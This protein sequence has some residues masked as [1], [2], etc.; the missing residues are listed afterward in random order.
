MP[1]LN[2]RV[3]GDIPWLASIELIHRGVRKLNSDPGNTKQIN[4]ERKLIW[5]Y[6]H[7]DYVP[8]RSQLR[9]DFQKDAQRAIPQ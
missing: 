5:V 9:C 7:N 8:L 3:L 4:R 6:S 1:A 2:L